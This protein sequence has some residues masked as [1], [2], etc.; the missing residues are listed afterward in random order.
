MEYLKIIPQYGL[1]GIAKVTKYE[2]IK[3]GYSYSIIENVIQSI[4]Y[5]E[6]NIKIYRYK[7]ANQ[8]NMQGEFTVENI[9]KKEY[10]DIVNVLKERRIT[11][12]I[13]IEEPYMVD[14]PNST[15][16]NIKFI[17]KPGFEVGYRKMYKLEYFESMVAAYPMPCMIPFTN[18]PYE[19]NVDTRKYKGYRFMPEESSFE[20]SV[21]KVV[22]PVK[23]KFKEESE[24]YYL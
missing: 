23:S 18:R 4:F 15:I 24:F 9:T 5:D 16:T 21:Y 13:E 6:S 10:Y 7:Y 14:V 12:R 2:G 20:K 11:D 17:P 19:V 8:I 22:W 3:K 1:T